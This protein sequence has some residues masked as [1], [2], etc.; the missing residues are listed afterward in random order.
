MYN[1]QNKQKVMKM[2]IK[3][4][5]GLIKENLSYLIVAVVGLVLL[6]VGGV[7]F[8]ELI[9]KILFFV[10]LLLSIISIILGLRNKGLEW[11]KFD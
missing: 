4:W 5:F 11:E 10:G 9:G 1:K 3:D 6:A 8:T 2:N 7:Y